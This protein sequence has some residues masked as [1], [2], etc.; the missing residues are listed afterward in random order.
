MPRMEIFAPAI[1][2]NGNVD[3]LKNYYDLS[4]V[5]FC[6]TTTNQGREIQHLP[7]SSGSSNDDGEEAVLSYAV[8]M[9]LWISKVN[10]G[11]VTKNR[12]AIRMIIATLAAAVIHVIS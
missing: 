12:L 6:F 5:V 2:V 7:S 4:N 3:N 11:S 1:N 8:S 10:S 9:D